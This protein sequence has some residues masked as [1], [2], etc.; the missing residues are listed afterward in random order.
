M[1]VKFIFDA[2]NLEIQW[3]LEESGF[4]L[5]CST[6]TEIFL[7]LNTYSSTTWSVVGSVHGCRTTHKEENLNCMQ[8]FNS[9]SVVAP[10]PSIVQGPTII[11]FDWFTTI[12]NN[13]LQWTISQLGFCK[14]CQKGLLTR[15]NE[16]F[17]PTSIYFY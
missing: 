11:L 14:Q 5:H 4:E 9:A 17:P 13:L 12:C 6:Y 7:S 10:N 2:P 1:F 16:I 8:I 3:T 15:K